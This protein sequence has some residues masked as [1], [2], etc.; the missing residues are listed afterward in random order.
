[1]EEFASY[2]ALLSKNATE[3]LI[4][5]MHEHQKQLAEC[6]LSLEQHRA[7]QSALISRWM[8]LMLVVL[9]AEGCVIVKLLIR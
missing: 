9:V 3:P 7:K 5:A 8:T 2:L 4:A 1:M 6:M